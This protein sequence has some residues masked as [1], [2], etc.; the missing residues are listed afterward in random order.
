MN[1]PAR[2]LPVTRRRERIDG[3]GAGLLIFCSALMGLNQVVVKVTNIGLQ[4]VFQAG[5]RSALAILPVLLVA[6][7]LRR[8]LTLRDGSLAPGIL[9]GVFFASEFLLLF[10]A[11]DHT[12]VARASVFFYTMP[13]WAAVGAHFMIPGENL[14]LVR[15]AGLVLAVAGVVVAMSDH[16]DTLRPTLRGDLYCLVAAVFWAGI[17]LVARTTSL[18]RACPEMQLLYQLVVSAVI[19][20]AAAAVVGDPVRQFTALTAWLVAFQ[21]LVVICLGFLVWFWVLSVYPAADMASFSFL[22]PVFGVI[23]GWLILGEDLTSSVLWALAMVCAGVYLVNRRPR[24][25]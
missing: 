19:L 7:A 4:P 16:F 13:F 22:A 8:R 15:L 24:I 6:M 23:F 1:D 12:T 14:T 18:S 17:I 11:L 2:S 21:V 9:A 5:L 20:M 10:P 25:P 3:L